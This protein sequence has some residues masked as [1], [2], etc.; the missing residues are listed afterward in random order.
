[1]PRVWDDCGDNI[2]FVHAVNDKAATDAA[3]AAAEHV[4]K[5]RFVINRVTAAT[6]EPRGSIGH[7]DAGEGRYTIYTTLQRAHVFRQELATQVPKVPESRIRVVAGDIGGSFGIKSAVYNEV[8][9][10]PCAQF[11][12]SRTKRKPRLLGGMPA[13]QPPP[14]AS[15][16][17][18]GM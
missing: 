4:V 11:S 1:M 12:S 17:K 7:Y 5:Q 3:F 15:R 6:M 13:E 9:L 16:M 10:I 8:A 14:R 18:S 2:C